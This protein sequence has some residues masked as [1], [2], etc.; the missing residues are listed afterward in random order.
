MKYFIEMKKIVIL[1]VLLSDYLVACEWCFGNEQS[2]MDKF[3]N[4]Q[5]SFT[6]NFEDS[7][8]DITEKVKNWLKGLPIHYETIPEISID[9][10]ME[11]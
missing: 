9:N 8:L 4:H 6:H 5:N 1:L 3:Q 11:R 7:E 2:P 10:T